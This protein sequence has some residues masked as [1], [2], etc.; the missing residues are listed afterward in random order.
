MPPD[1]PLQQAE[2]A[3]NA[4]IGDYVWKHI[5]V[6]GQESSA[7]AAAALCLFRSRSARGLGSRRPSDEL[8]KQLP[9]SSEPMVPHAPVTRIE[10]P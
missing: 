3:G 1:D 2:Y 6:F 10:W 7:I 5:G 4:P 8:G 9:I